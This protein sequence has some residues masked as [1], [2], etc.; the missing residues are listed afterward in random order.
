MPQK[1]G[2]QMPGWQMQHNPGEGFPLNPNK[3]TNCTDWIFRNFSNLT[4]NRCWYIAPS[5][6][7]ISTSVHFVDVFYRQQGIRRPQDLINY[8]KA[9]TN[10][11]QTLIFLARKLFW[12][13]GGGAVLSVSC[14]ICIFLASHV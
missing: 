4:K 1:W 6:I 7:H 10:S 2:W 5:H 14:I 11:L 9:L 12:G 3:N 8:L 13:L